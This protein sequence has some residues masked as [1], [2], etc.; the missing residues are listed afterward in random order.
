M[1]MI[2]AGAR[3]AERTVSWSDGQI[4]EVQGNQLVHFVH[5][6]EIRICPRSTTFFAASYGWS[7]TARFAVIVT[8]F[9]SCTF[10]P[11]FGVKFE[12]IPLSGEERYGK[13]V[14]GCAQRSFGQEERGDGDGKTGRRRRERSDAQFKIVK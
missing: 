9:P 1:I 13:T 6:L 3:H 4:S 7:L 5:G 2:E 8:T 10:P 14:A 11:N 12:M